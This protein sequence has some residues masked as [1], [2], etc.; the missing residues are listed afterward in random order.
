VV[1]ELL[2]LAA[3]RL[4]QRG[5]DDAAPDREVALLLREQERVRRWRAAR[6]RRAGR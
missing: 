1:P 4:E 6:V 2:A 5:N 3:E